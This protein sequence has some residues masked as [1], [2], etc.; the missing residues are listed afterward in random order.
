M[1]DDYSLQEYLDAW[2]DVCCTPAD[3]GDEP[4]AFQFKVLNDPASRAAN[5]KEGGAAI[6]LTMRDHYKWHPLEPRPTQ[7]LHA[8]LEAQKKAGAMEYFEVGRAR[9]RL[10]IDPALIPK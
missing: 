9:V 5:R 7:C 3:A 8:M 6:A 4:G 2:G 10:E 1:Q